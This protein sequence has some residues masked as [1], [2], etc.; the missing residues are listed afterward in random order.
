ML[1]QGKTVC[2]GCMG[3]RHILSTACKPAIT[4]KQ[5]VKKTV[6]KVLNSISQLLNLLY[7]IA[8]SH[9]GEVKRYPCGM[10]RWFNC[11]LLCNKRPQNIVAW[12]NH[13]F[14][15][16]VLCQE[17]KLVWADILIH[18][19]SVGVIHLGAFSSRG[20]ARNL[21]QSGAA[22]PAEFPHSMVVTG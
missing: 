4:S 2:K 14:V 22:W 7:E 5:K 10:Q 12:N 20:W 6:K 3:S 9:V 21:K 11:L 13:Y 1:P 18:V 16:T 19:L 17:L 8:A 15:F